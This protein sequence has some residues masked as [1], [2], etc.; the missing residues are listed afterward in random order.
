[1]SVNR[2]KRLFAFCVCLSLCVSFCAC[3]HSNTQSISSYLWTLEF[4]SDL[5]GKLL[6]S[7]SKQEGTK[8][9]DLALR[10]DG[11]QFSLKDNTSNQTW[12]GSYSLE[13]TSKS[14]RL[15]LFFENSTKPVVGVY[16]TRV[17]S[18]NSKK[19]TITLQTDD[20][21]LSFVGADL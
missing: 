20:Y 21:I 8:Q 17:Y 19:A 4:V 14:Y 2:E 1:M 10:F 7:G 9:M 3:S 11:K 13:R 18:D 5:D 15:E 12:T 6:F 16:G